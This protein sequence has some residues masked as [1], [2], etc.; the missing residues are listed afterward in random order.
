VRSF[1]TNMTAGMFDFEVK[2]N[3]SVDNEAEIS[4]PPAV[5]FDNSTPAQQAQP[6]EAN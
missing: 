1:P 5:T 3:F 4:A 2:P 6:V